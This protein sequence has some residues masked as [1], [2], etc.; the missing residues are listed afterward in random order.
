MKSQILI[1]ILVLSILAT[2]DLKA[3]LYKIPFE[4][5]LENSELIVEGKVIGQTSYIANEEVYTE[6]LIEISKVIKGAYAD[7]TLKIITMGGEVDGFL[8]TWT[9]LAKLHL[10]EYGIFFLKQTERPLNMATG[11]NAPAFD[12][13]SSS[14]GVYRIFHEGKNKTKAVSALDEFSR[15]EQ[16]YE[17]LSYDDSDSKPL[18]EFG[19]KDGGEERNCIIYKIEPRT[20]APFSNPTQVE[21]DIFVKV[22]SSGFPLYKGNFSLKYDTVV[23]GK[24]IV[25]NGYLTF[26]NGE[27][28]SS[29]YNL[30]FNDLADDHFEMKLEA[31]TTNLSSLETV[32]TAYK[33]VAT[34]Y[35]TILGWSGG[36]VID[37]DPEL[38]L[39]EN[40][41]IEEGTGF[42]KE[43]DCTKVVFSEACPNITEITPL[44]AAARVGL[45]SENG[46]PGVITIKGTDFTDPMPGEIIPENYRVKFKNAGTDGEWI[47][48]FEGD[49]I[50]WT[51]TEIKVKVPSVGYRNN[52]DDIEHD[53][54]AGTG[55]VRVVKVGAFC[56]SLCFGTSDDEL[57]IPFATKNTYQTNA[58]GWKESVRT[59]LA[60]RDG[61][62]GYSFY[63]KDNFKNYPGAVDA[64][65]RALETW[66]CATFV[67]FDVRELSDIPNISGAC[68]IDLASLPAGVNSTTRAVTAID[69]E[70]CGDEP[71]VLFSYSPSMWMKFRD[72]KEDGTAID[73]HTGTNMPTLNWDS[74]IDLE[75]IALHE[76]GHAHLLRHTKNNENVMFPS[77]TEYRRNLTMD[78]ENGGNHIVE[79]STQ[80]PVDC[81][82]SGMTKLSPA[83]CGIT[84]IIETKESMIVVEI[85]PNP[86]FDKVHIRI[87]NWNFN[88]GTSIVLRNELGQ[89]ML[90]KNITGAH[91]ILDVSNLPSG[92]YIVELAA[93]EGQRIV[94]GKFSKIWKP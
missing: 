15:L 60:N 51:D 75:T 17:R 28:N 10:N 61:D 73:W 38:S 89:S 56:I 83:D 94:L 76:L 36:E 66:R 91:T 78:D 18:F 92:I 62:G 5:K 64:F 22:D 7:P 47:A 29:Y 21:A 77:A 49:Y 81:P 79:L 4:Q 52:C 93:S 12:I 16:L 39:I 40:Y 57:Y 46:I 9:H 1:S 87:I 82:S 31:N 69:P 42:V 27:F 20:I 45:M 26:T 35:L 14:Q 24:N 68:F 13:Y 54:Y 23:F 48:P 86:A 33:K 37:W 2:T 50:S 30:S 67:N 63:F 80:S 3:Q 59:L 34:V 32:D 25:Q 90:E 58:G 8:F 53:S 84:P 72:K 55:K 19:Q 44:T 88:T 11:K 70:N 85:Y 74:E 41:Y 43:F 65:K 71:N 6:N